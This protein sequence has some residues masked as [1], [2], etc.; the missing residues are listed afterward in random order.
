MIVV[1]CGVG[2]AGAGAVVVA[3]LTGG[4]FVS[5][6]LSDAGR[7]LGVLGGGES[8]GSTSPVTWRHSDAS[9]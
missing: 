9:S 5:L 8:I 7:V 3:I 2:A 4:R 1:T 6:A